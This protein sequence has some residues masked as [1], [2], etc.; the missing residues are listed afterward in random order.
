MINIMYLVLM[1]LLALNVSAEV[2]NAFQTLDEGN[3]ASIATVDQQVD[4]S[5]EGLE[6]LIEDAEGSKDNFKPLVPAV[7]DIRTI[8]AEF[9]QYVEGLR[10]QLVDMAGNNN[11]ELD[12]QDYKVD[13]GVRAPVGKKNKDVTTRLLVLGD[14]GAG[15]EVGEGETLKQ[16]IVDTRQALLDRYGQLLEQN[17]EE[18]EI[19]QSEIDARLAAMDANMPFGIDDEAWREA[20]RPS[21]SDYKFGHMP[22][23]A[24]LPLMSQMQSDLTVSEA[25]LVNDIVSIAGGKSIVIDQFFPVL[26]ADRSYVTE[27]ETINAEVSVGSYSSSLDPSNVSL[28]VNDQRLTIGP[29]G[30]AKYTL[31]GNGLGK[32]T[33]RTRV[34]VRNPLTGEVKT[35]EGSYV[36]EVGKSSAA[37][38][39]EKMNVFYIGVKNPVKVSA[40]GVSSNAVNVSVNGNARKSGG[41]KLEFD[42][43][44]TAAGTATVV[45]TAGGEQLAAK[46]FRV[47][48]I[49]DPVA[50]IGG[51]REGRVRSN[52]FSAQKGLYAELEDFDFEAKC[53]IS[54]YD[55]YYLPAGRDAVLSSN[56]GGN[57][58]T[59][60]KALVN[61]LKPGDKVSILNIK[62]K[63]PGDGG[64]RALGSMA[65]IIN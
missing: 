54:G 32:K 64:P 30:K 44:G 24:V 7:K 12:E 33:V 65:F 46:E 57:F 63:C 62:G 37:V 23:A 42:V 26:N 50:K 5:V 18:M 9:N 43:E 28:F 55:F 14:D 40:A 13:H 29:D 3:Q 35:G 38:S 1:A 58:T 41:S 21:W 17:G 10:T 60:T 20:D 6:K 8:A 16:R 34:E 27:G 31:R 36:Y 48:R 49:P 56:P 2:M 25:N 52:V 15:P 11:G 59:K 22:V 53:N 45:V 51:K 4:E 61:R 47:K 39:A 19:D